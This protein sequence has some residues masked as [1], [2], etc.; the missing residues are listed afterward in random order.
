MYRR[1]LHFAAIVTAS[2]LF[3]GGC[4]H[5]SPRDLYASVQQSFALVARESVEDGESL[6]SEGSG[7]LVI[8]NGT[9]YL[10]T[11]R[12]IY[13]D[14]DGNKPSGLYITTMD[15]VS[16]PVTLTSLEESKLN[17]DIVRFVV[18][19]NDCVGL[20]LATTPLH[21][22]DTIYCFGNA[23]GAGVMNMEEGRVLAV[24]PLE[25]EHTAEVVK[26]MSGG[27]IV[28][29]R[30]EVVGLCQKGRRMTAKEAGTILCDGTKYIGRLRN[31]G[32]N[33][34]TVLW[35]CPQKDKE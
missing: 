29:E 2:I 28:N 34:N 19:N 20:S 27:P 30:G 13:F 3:L 26:G 15:G 32:A 4:C 9:N 18:S 8:E 22:G 35:S 24:G 10:Y 5:P 23:F 14:K 16:S 33:G 25:F 17:H 31:F 1:I 21:Y 6:W 7:F 12:H 11:A